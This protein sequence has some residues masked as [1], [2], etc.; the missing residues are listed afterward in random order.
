MAE[1]LNRRWMNPCPK[2]HPTI[3]H[4]KG[5]LQYLHMINKVPLV[6]LTLCV[7][8]LIVVFYTQNKMPLVWLTLC[9]VCLIVN[10]T[11][12]KGLLQ[13]LHIDKALLVTLTLGVPCLII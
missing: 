10:F 5:L 13:Y 1:D 9:V 3:Y 8:C 6:R 12:T 7:P 4:T 11:N 2:L